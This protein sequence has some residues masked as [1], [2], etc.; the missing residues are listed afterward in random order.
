MIIRSIILSD[1]GHITYYMQWYII[2]L[3]RLL[4]LL[5][6]YNQISSGIMGLFTIAYHHTVTIYH[7]LSE[8]SQTTEPPVSFDPGYQFYPY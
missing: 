7:V 5:C 1:N 8:D 2:P 3:S 4:S 6:I